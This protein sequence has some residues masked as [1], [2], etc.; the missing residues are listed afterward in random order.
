MKYKILIFLFCFSC[1][2]ANQN[3]IKSSFQT[4][5]FA[6]IYNEDDRLKK[7]TNKKFDNL[8]LSISHDKIKSGSLL[9]ITNPNNKKFIILKTEKKTKYPDLYKVLITEA[10]ADYLSLDK[11]IPLV[12]VQEIIKNKSFIADRAE[13]F[14]EE[15]KVHN[16]APITNVK[17]DNISKIEIKTKKTVKKFSILIGEFST[18]KS[19]IYLKKKLDVE[20]LLSNQKLLQINKKSEKSYQLL[21]GPFISVNSLK[22]DYIKLHKF[23]FE[24]L[25]IKTYE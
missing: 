23:G 7:I 12:D 16:K 11:N 9:R 15:K 5:G 10:V 20:I 19:A 3:I 1:T 14:N 13:T 2:G 17:I 22:N 24:D 21:L 18:A 6:Y 8:K 4:K 25:E